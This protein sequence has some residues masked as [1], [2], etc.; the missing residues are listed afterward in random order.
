MN[1]AKNLEKYEVIVDSRESIRLPQEIREKFNIS[2]GAIFIVKPDSDG[3]LY[4]I[5]KDDK[6]IKKELLE[7]KKKFLN[8]FKDI[9][10]S[11]KEDVTSEEFIKKERRF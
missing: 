4:L 3:N 8:H 7:K 5:K 6:I 10:L 9:D 11:K 2:K 1:T